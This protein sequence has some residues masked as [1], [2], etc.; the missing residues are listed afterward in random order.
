MTT[1]REAPIC[2]I[3][4]WEVY[5]DYIA[6]REAHYEMDIGLFRHADA[7]ALAR[8]DAHMAAKRW[9]NVDEFQAARARL[10]GEEGTR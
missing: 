6:C 2:I 1:L 5:R 8:W 9:C 7:A 3:G 4:Q 10:L